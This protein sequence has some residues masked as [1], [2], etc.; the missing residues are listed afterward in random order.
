M[1]D[2]PTPYAPEGSSGGV[3]P[4]EQAE[5]AEP[6]DPDAWSPAGDHETA[7]RRRHRLRLPA[8]LAAAAIVGGGLVVAGEQVTRIGG[9]PSPQLSIASGSHTPAVTTGGIDAAAV[10]ARVEPAVVDVTAQVLELG[11]TGTSAGTGMIVTSRGEVVTNNHVVQGSTS[12]SVEVPAQHRSYAARVIAVD[13]S[14]DIA[15]LQMEGASGLPTVTFANPV[16]VRVGEPV[17]AIGNAYGLGGTP[18]VSSGTI[19][20]LDRPVTASNGQ[21]SS[22]HLTGMLQT[23]ARLARGDSGGPLVD[24]S[25]DV[26]GMDTAAATT[27][28]SA[29]TSTIAFAIPSGRVTSVVGSIQ[30]GTQ[31]AAILRTPPA[32]LGVDVSTSGPGLNGGIPGFGGDGGVGTVPQTPGALVLAVVPGTPAAQLGLQPGDVITSAAGHPITSRGALRAIIVGRRPG[33]RLALNWL[34]G[35]TRYHGTVTLATGPVA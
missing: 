19:V 18:A 31:S 3:P 14:R 12:V 34:A 4:A 25:G 2:E 23:N 5:Q 28:F 15:L 35:P 33:Q 11:G 22:E 26:V 6:G 17:V 29:Q 8:A 10:A 16:D 32:F 1:T 27:P 21:S 9:G 30:R 13:P 7:R 24:A 20:A